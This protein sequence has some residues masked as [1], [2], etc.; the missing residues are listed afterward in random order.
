[1]SK[2]EKKEKLSSP[3]ASQEKLGG[4]MILSY[5]GAAVTANISNNLRS[6]YHMSFLSDVVKLDVGFVGGFTTI[7]SIWNALIKPIVGTIIDRTNTSMGRY[8]PWI[9][10]GSILY[11]ILGVLLFIIPTGMSKATLATFYIV[12]LFI[13]YAAQTF[14]V[15]PWQAFNATL[16]R[17]SHQRNRILVAR[18]V[19]GYAASF[20]VALVL[21]NI[22]ESFPEESTGWAIVGI[23][24]GIISLLCGLQFFFTTKNYDVP[25]SAETAKKEKRSIIGQIKLA[26]KNRALVT[27]SL[28]LGLIYLTSMITSTS[29]MYFYRG[30]LGSTD[31]V[32]LIAIAN[33]LACFVV[34]PF[35]PK[36]LKKIS[37]TKLIVIFVFVDAI[38]IPYNIFMRHIFLANDYVVSNLALYSYVGVYTLSTVGFILAQTGAN[39]LAVDVTD[40]TEWKFGTVD[41]GFVTSVTSM[42]RN[43]LGGLSTGIVGALLAMVNYTGYDALT[44][45]IK[46]MIINIQIFPKAVIVVL[47][48]VLVGL[49]PIKGEFE[50]KMRADLSERREAAANA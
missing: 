47:V 7:L 50:K 27:S 12:V 36:I 21:M 46:S 25:V 3:E 16:S 4:G 24:V 49:Y 1:M 6:T 23:G 33:M 8:R 40:Y 35:I 18:Q 9:L 2:R 11:S 14:F 45:E 42:V 22:I 28:A 44:Y 31:P 26:V 37:K 30:V 48:L 5:G 19:G 29:S 17:D 41:A 34:V 15:M 38:T 20:A 10:I 32:S 13:Y 39:A 43:L